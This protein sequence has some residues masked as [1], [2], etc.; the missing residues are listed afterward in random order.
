MIF[1]KLQ[2]LDDSKTLEAV[3]RKK[4][5]LYKYINKSIMIQNLR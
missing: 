2:L 3:Y 4:L 5:E 1:N